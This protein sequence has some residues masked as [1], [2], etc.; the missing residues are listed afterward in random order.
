MKAALPAALAPQLATLAS[1]VPAQG[2]WH[3]E[4][5]FDGYRLLARVDDRSRPALHAQRQ[6]LDATR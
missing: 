6:R 5:K 3:Y 4:L 2:A 1:S